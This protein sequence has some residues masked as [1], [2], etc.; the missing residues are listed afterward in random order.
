MQTQRQDHME[1]TVLKMEK[2]PSELQGIVTK[3]REKGN[4]MRLQQRAEG[5]LDNL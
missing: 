4:K 3:A 1:T 2:S 5:A